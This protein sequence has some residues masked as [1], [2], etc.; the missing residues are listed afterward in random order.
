M[1]KRYDKPDKII[2]TSQGKIKF[3]YKQLNLSTSFT[4]QWINISKITSKTKAKRN[5]KKK[6][7]N[8]NLM[9]LN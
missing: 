3:D 2:V 6:C 5:Y 1:I 8:P 4:I 7:R 9:S